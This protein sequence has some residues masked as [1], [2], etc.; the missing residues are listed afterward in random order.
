MGLSSKAID[1]REIINFCDKNVIIMRFRDKNGGF[2][3]FIYTYIHIYIHIYHHE[4]F[5]LVQ[6]TV[7][8]FCTLTYI[9]CLSSAIF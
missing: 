8:L 6:K 9:A 1:E 3:L 7:F 5:I 2:I 4:Y